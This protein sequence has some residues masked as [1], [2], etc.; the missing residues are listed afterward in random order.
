MKFRKK[1]FCFGND[2]L[3][4][5]TPSLLHPVHLSSFCKPVKI[6]YTLKLPLQAQIYNRRSRAVVQNHPELN[7]AVVPFV[8]PNQD[9]NDNQ[10]A[11][12]END[13]QHA[14]QPRNSTRIL[15]VVQRPRDRIYLTED[16]KGKQMVVQRAQNVAKIQRKQRDVSV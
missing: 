7:Q 16:H 10:L 6:Y 8:P 5:F 3:E 2:L 12:V 9:V 15:A 1:L 13:L 11:T 4:Y 14:Y